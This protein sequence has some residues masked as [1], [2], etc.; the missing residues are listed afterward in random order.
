MT[1][2]TPTR[3]ATGL[4]PLRAALDLAAT[5]LPAL[6][7]SR[8]K[9]PFR[10]CRACAALACGG[11]PNM[12]DAGPCQCPRP[13]HGWAA[14][15]TDP[16]LITSPA[17]VAAWERAATVA[18]HP[19]G[20]GLTVVD[21]DNPAAVTW[22]RAILPPTRTVASTRGEHWIYR[23]TTRSSNRVRPGTDIKSLMAYARYLGPGHGTLAP[24]PDAVRALVTREEATPPRAPVASS[25]PGREWDRKVATGCRHTTT[26]VRAGL[27]R[28]LA[29]IRACVEQGAGSQAFGVARFLAAQHHACPGP[30]D[31]PTIGHQ[32]TAAAVAVGVPEPYA[33]RAVARGFREA[34]GREAA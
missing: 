15:T 12:L 17:W 1:Q 2:P 31:L 23:G 13:C 28:G 9:R 7:L 14:A 4:D 22:A 10:N 6:P 18:Y 5:G 30:C 27:D 32:I 11:R 21:L 26:Y 8:G 3:R 29:K 19:G 34:L 33:A 25:L 20:A 24:L 16:D